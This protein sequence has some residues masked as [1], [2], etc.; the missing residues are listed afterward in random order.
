MVTATLYIE[1][2]GEGREL[3]ARFREGWKEFFNSAGVGGRTKIVR[4]G[5][6]R[7]TFAR[8]ATAVSDN[9]PGTVPFLLVD[10]E[11]PVAPRHSVWQ[12]LRARDR[13][14]S[15]LRSA[16]DDRAFLMVQVMETWFLADRG[17]LRMY[18]GTR[19]RENSLRAW[20]NLEDVP[21]STVL[22]ALERATASCRKPYSKGFQGQGLVR[23]AG[24]NRSRPRR[25]RLSA[26]Q[27][28]PGRVEG[29]ATEGKCRDGA[30]RQEWRYRHDLVSDDLA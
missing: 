4:G 25:S 29:V 13:L 6:R 2:G 26:R 8:F 18:F 15:G 10:S 23:A 14:E 24:A 7:Q 19:F 27:G 16:G 20:P 22:G 17:A 12:H 1:G 21:K 28:I 30:M 5:G 9:S 11:G 3:R